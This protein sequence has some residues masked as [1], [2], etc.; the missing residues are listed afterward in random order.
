MQF[1]PTSTQNICLV[2]VRTGFNT[3]VVG[4]LNLFWGPP[5]K[6]KM[7]TKRV[8][9]APKEPKRV[10]NKK[11]KFSCIFYQLSFLPSSTVPIWFN[12]SVR[13]RSAMKKQVLIN[14]LYLA[15]RASYF[16]LFNMTFSG[17]LT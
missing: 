4:F 1:F 5:M 11:K 12:T 2:L 3:L 10:Q 8:F 6:I 13:L 14:E 17:Y 15:A 9:N 7:K 16:R